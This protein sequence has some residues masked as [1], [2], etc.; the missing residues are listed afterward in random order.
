MVLA[1]DRPVAIVAQ[2]IMTWLDWAWTV[3]VTGAV[4]A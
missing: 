4:R 2:Q 1:N 3:R